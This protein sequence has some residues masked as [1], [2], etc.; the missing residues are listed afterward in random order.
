MGSLIGINLNLTFQYGRQQTVYMSTVACE[1]GAKRGERKALTLL[2]IA[3]QAS[4]Q[5]RGR[6]VEMIVQCT[7][8]KMIR[9]L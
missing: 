3:T 4:Q 1:A 8:F 9:H 2:T 6:L 5:R 7:S